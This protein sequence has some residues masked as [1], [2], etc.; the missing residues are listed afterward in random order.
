MPTGASGK[1]PSPRRLLAKLRGVAQTDLQAS[2]PSSLC[3]CLILLHATL[4]DSGHRAREERGPQASTRIR[5]SQY[6]LSMGLME[7]SDDAR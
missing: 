4:L 6:S 7:R 3:T 5:I 2:T 1:E